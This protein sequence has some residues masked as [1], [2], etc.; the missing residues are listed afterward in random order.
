MNRP[1]RKDGD[2]REQKD[3][4][5]YALCDWFLGTLLQFISWLIANGLDIGLLRTE[6]GGSRLAMFFVL[7]VVTSAITLGL[8]AWIERRSLPIRYFW[9]VYGLL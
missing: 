3:D 9:L 8:F 4:L 1:W 2:R 7:D 5:P 6:L